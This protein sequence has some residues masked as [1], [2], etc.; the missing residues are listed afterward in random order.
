M[1]REKPKDETIDEAVS[2][3]VYRVKEGIV[4]DLASKTQTFGEMVIADMLEMGK[5]VEE[6]W[7]LIDIGGAS[8][9]GQAKNLISQE[10]LLRPEPEEV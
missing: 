7:E 8:T 4:G 10:A 2:V 1:S 5:L 9:R 6:E 3:V